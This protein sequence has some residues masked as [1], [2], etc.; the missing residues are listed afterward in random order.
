MAGQ[1]SPQSDT[2]A[3]RDS[4]R[5][6]AL[7]S[8]PLQKSTNVFQLGKGA[9]RGSAVHNKRE[10]AKVKRLK[11]IRAGRSFVVQTTNDVIEQTNKRT[12][13]KLT[14]F[15]QCNNGTTKPQN[16]NN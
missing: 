6:A 12:N 4:A 9:D 11:K 8:P 16:R 14:N 7:P 5:L 13:D 2:A 1:S 3:P 15:E 10:C